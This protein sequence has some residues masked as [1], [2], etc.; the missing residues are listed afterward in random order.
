MICNNGIQAF[1]QVSNKSCFLIGCWMWINRYGPKFYKPFA[2]NDRNQ[3]YNINTDS[4][5]MKMDQ[6]WIRRKRPAAA[7]HCGQQ[8]YR[9]QGQLK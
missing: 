4:I 6:V 3:L 9:R 8:L 5:N 2:N 7:S 1:S